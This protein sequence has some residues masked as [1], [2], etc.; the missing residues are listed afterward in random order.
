MYDKHFIT[1]QV[2]DK[3]YNKIYPVLHKKYDP[4]TRVYTKDPRDCDFEFKDGKLIYKNSRD[5]DFSEA[6][7]IFPSFKNSD[8]ELTTQ[9]TISYY[10]NNNIVPVRNI[11]K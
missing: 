1:Y 11:F 10:L 9:E 3:Y 8:K 4:N 6:N 2:K 7:K 5:L